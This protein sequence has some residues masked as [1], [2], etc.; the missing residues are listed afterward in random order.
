MNKIKLLLLGLGALL[1]LWIAS[2]FG[3]FSL[4]GS[5]K[6]ESKDINPVVGTQPESQRVRVAI[7][8]ADDNK[9]EL[10]K[11]FNSEQTAY[12][13]LES[14]ASENSLELKTQQYDFGV[15]IKSIDDF[16]SGAD[17]AWI[18]FVNGESGQIAADQY[19]VKPGDNV[20][21]K[22]ITPSGE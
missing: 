22:Y 7:I 21:W 18:Y 15:F 11:E 2:W 8:F 6:N 19:K 13:L 14:I 17:K 3:L 9:F 5:S 12:S 4:I 1:I 20:E 10:S 16:E